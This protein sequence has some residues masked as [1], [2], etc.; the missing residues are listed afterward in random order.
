MGGMG[1]GGGEGGLSESVKKEK[2]DENLFLDNVERSSKNLWKMIFAKGL[3]TNNF[4][5]A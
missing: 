4:H 2:I 1:G 3:S 5:H